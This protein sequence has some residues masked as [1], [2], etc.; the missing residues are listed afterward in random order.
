MRRYSTMLAFLMLLFVGAAWGALASAADDNGSAAAKGQCVKDANAS[1]R[2]IDNGDGTISDRATCLMWEKKDDAGGIHDKDNLYTN[3]TCKD[4]WPQCSLNGTA[5]T[6]F[7]AKLNTKPC[8]AGYCDWRLPE[9]GQ[10]PDW[11][12]DYGPSGK[13]AE[14]ETIVAAPYPGFLTIPSKCTSSPCVDPVFNNNCGVQSS[15][16]KGCTV[17]GKGGKACSCTL[18]GPYASGTTWRSHP[19]HVP[20]V[21]F[22]G[23]WVSGSSKQF[24]HSVRAVR[25]M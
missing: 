24:H 11:P 3:S 21:D 18:P 8:F 23:G 17:D 25:S 22:Q 15:G 5:V 19:W 1:P 4:D 13:P 7:L 9:S 10:R 14:L 20:V 6:D 12:A 16:N 2:L